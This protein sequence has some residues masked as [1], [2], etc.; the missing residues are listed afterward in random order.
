MAS[1]G[2]TFGVLWEVMDSMPGHMTTLQLSR[3]KESKC[4]VSL[5]LSPF[6][7][8]F[9]TISM[10][11]VVVQWLV[12][13][14]LCWEV[15]GQDLAGSL[16]CVLG[17]NS[18]LSQCFAPIQSINRYWQTVRKAWNGGEVT[19]QWTVVSSRG[20][21]T[22]CSWNLGELQEHGPFCL[23]DIYLFR[24]NINTSLQSERWWDKI[25][26]YKGIGCDWTQNSQH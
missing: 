14:T 10:G 24:C 15:W 4:S 5:K 26:M 8:F 16:S 7:F 25:N 13:W 12:S 22:F 20:S 17:K 9:I 18:L 11:D 2:Q 19:L 6:H 23:I 3:G 21:N 1:Y